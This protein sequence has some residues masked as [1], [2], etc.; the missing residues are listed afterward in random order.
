M[1]GR[2]RLTLAVIALTS[3][4][5][6]ALDLFA[7]TGKANVLVFVTSDCPISNTY[8]SD[9]QKICAGSKSR[10]VACTLIYEDQS[11]D[12][13]GVRKHGQAFGYRDMA[14]V[15]DRDGSLAR[16]AGAT[17]TPEVAVIAPGGAVK[18]RGR[19]DNR[20]VAIGKARQVVT[21]YDLRDAIENVLAG[22]PVAHPQTEAFGCFIPPHRYTP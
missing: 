12:E 13:A 14:T 10:G 9:I 5:L 6:S 19:I 17:V 15:I 16:R 4:A 7:P 20:Y 3:V 21:A 8:A 22:R 1:A 11:I 18:Y 2:L